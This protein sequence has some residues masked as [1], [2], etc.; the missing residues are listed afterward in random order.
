[1]K[2]ILIKFPHDLG[3]AVQ[4]TAV[5]RHIRA[6]RPD[7]EVD[8]LSRPGVHSAFGG[9]CRRSYGTSEPQPDAKDYDRVFDIAWERPSEVY[10]GF[11]A[12]PAAGVLI[13]Q[14]GIQPDTS[15]YRPQIHVGDEARGKAT[16]YLRA[17]SKDREKRDGRFPILLVHYRGHGAPREEDLVRDTAYGV[18][19]AARADGLVPVIIDFNGRSPLCDQ[20]TIF[21]ANDE[22]AGLLGKA[23][24]EDA[25]LLT[26]LV[27]QAWM[28]VSIDGGPLQVAGATSTPTL[29]VW[30]RRFPA[31]R[32]HPADNVTHWIPTNWHELGPA[33]DPGLVRYLQENYRHKVYQH[34][35]A[36]LVT[37][38]WPELPKHPSKRLFRCGPFWI[39]RDNAEQDLVIV[40]DVFGRDGYQT[41]LLPRGGDGEV[42]VDV[43][44]H[45]GCF[46]RLWHKRN[47]RAKII[48]VEA[49]PENIEALRANAGE[50]AE[51]VHAACTYES[52][53]VALL[54][55]VF[56]NCQ[57][58]GGS[59][60]V[61]R[62]QLETSDLKQKGYT[63][64]KDL[65]ELP[66]VTLED[67]MDRFA[68]DRIDVLKLD[69]EGSE[70]SI[71]GNTPSLPLIRTVV[72]EYHVRDRWDKLRNKRMPGWDYRHLYEGANSLGLFHCT[73]PFWPPVESGRRLVA[74]WPKLLS[75]PLLR[76]AAPGG[77]GD[78]LWVATKISALLRHYGAQNVLLTMCSGPPYRLKPFVERFDFIES[79][80]YTSLKC[81][82]DNPF[83]PE[84]TLNWKPSSVGWHGQ[85]DFFLQA[86]RHLERGGRLEDWLS[87]LDT[88]WD[89]ARRFRL[90][91]EELSQ[92]RQLE[93]ELGPY[94]VFYLGPEQGN[95]VYGHNRGPLW[96]PE[97]W[98]RL[99][100]LCRSLGLAV[101]VVGAEYD[102]S[103]FEQHV[104]KHLGA[105]YDAIGHWQI[106]RTFAV[107]RRARFVIAYQS[108]IGI[109]AVY[110]GVPSAIFWRPHGDS[111]Q[112]KHYVSFSEQMASAW[113]PP[114]ALGSGR[115]LPL[116][117][118]R[119]SPESI[120]E[121]AVTH[122]WHKS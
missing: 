49:C 53:P 86:N 46:A 117:Y 80:E 103:Y 55:A 20:N 71:L 90:T 10:E 2:S 97:D 77:I 62:S 67:L 63:Y 3:A 27:E 59:V 121:H 5:L 50:F 31:E 44:A 11:P 35:L 60:V 79:A 37:T 51:I 18:C 61:P 29:A 30:S 110:M 107:I 25:E 108:G 9:L 15:L 66:T 73:N 56:P 13:E 92:A 23:G 14:F 94:C 26:A 40:R 68:L 111:I 83:T 39:R 6:R 34:L 106:A 85:F 104:A 119:C 88:E 45:I 57:S 19:L 16:D 114:E 78:W 91:P 24:S 7:W 22:S 74:S 109:F 118:T 105:C 38:I 52:E 33:R 1:M 32:F 12:T 96:K 41:H 116:I 102:R 112:P 47:P 87:G 115:Y 21:W 72:G 8:V 113:A 99:A 81:V 17:V 95:T 58:T 75:P 101:V 98:G 93:T 84:G 122:D 54:N 69:C 48:C 120:V 42:V 76:L 4:F 100:D 28:L 82:E 64:Q 36:E 65:R 89:I 43:G 70:L